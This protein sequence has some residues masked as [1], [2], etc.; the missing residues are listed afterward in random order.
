MSVQKCETKA[1]H[2][3]SIMILLLLLILSPSVH[4]QTGGTSNGTHTENKPSSASVVKSRPELSAHQPP[5]SSALIKNNDRPTNDYQADD[6]DA[7]YVF[8]DMDLLQNDQAAGRS[9][10]YGNM[11]KQQQMH[12]RRDPHHNNSPH[13]GDDSVL[14]T[15]EV[16]I[17]QGP[18]KG[19]VRAMHAQS[20]LKS[21]DQ[22][23]GIPY[24]APPTGSGRFMPPGNIIWF[25]NFASF[26][27]LFLSRL[28]NGHK[29]IL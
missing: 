26:F 15:K 19:I 17:R 12:E 20:G 4:P 9:Y 22:Y 3:N 14:Y 1:L 8:E 13:R 11:K 16:H 21:V 5:T 28:L 2:Y 18:L 23:L 29:M 27:S 7:N 25:S 6:D 24:A 10:T